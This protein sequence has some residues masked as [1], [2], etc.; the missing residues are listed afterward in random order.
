MAVLPGTGLHGQTYR[1]M[2]LGNSL[3]RG[4]MC[5]N[6]SISPCTDISDEDAVGYREVLFDMLTSAGHDFDFVGSESGGGAIM[7]DT[8]HAGFPGIRDHQLASVMETGFSIYTGLVTPGPYLESFPADIILLHIG[9]NDM[10]A[11]DLAVDGVE[12]ILDAID[13]F[14]TEFGH[15]IMV[16]LA[17]IISTRGNPCDTDADVVEFNGNLDALAASRNALGD[18]IIVVDM[19]CGAGLDYSADM[20]DQVHPNQAGYDKMGQTW[21]DSVDAYLNAIP[22]TPGGLTLGDETFS[23]IGLSWTDYADNETGFQIERSLTSSGGD[24]S[25]IATVPANTTLYTSNGLTP[26]TRY[27]Y[28]IRAINNSGASLYTAVES[29]FTLPAPPAA[30]TGLSATAVDENTIDLTWTDTN[31]ENSYTIERSLTSGAGFTEVTTLSANT[32]YY[33]NSGLT[34]GTRYYYRIYATNPGGNSG[35][36]NEASATTDLAPPTNLAATAL[37]EQSI[38]LTWTDVSTHETGY[39]IERSLTS[40]S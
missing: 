5:T 39:K 1:I 21:Y 38:R 23:S 18:N 33:R 25:V 17:R 30:P 29:T 8:D 11:G 3:T 13:D 7:T 37:D 16:F 10:L 35:F 40:G 9:T 20:I 34:E 26:E 24:F 22:L 6:G 15:P 32:T 27:Y 28:R 4:T 36:S 12:R 19:E 2:P 14:E 31:N